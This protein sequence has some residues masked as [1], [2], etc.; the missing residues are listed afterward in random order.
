MGGRHGIGVEALAIGSALP[1]IAVTNAVMRRLA[2]LKRCCLCLGNDGSEQQER[3]K[4]SEHQNG[5]VTPEACASRPVA[6]PPL[7]PICKGDRRALHNCFSFAGGS[8]RVRCYY[9]QAVGP[10]GLTAS[11][12]APAASREGGRVRQC[13]RGRYGQAKAQHEPQRHI[14]P[15]VELA[16]EGQNCSSE[17][18]KK[19]RAC[20]LLFFCLYGAS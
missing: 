8:R 1:V 13:G 20:A 4:K 3:R 15:L 10:G 19:R 7:C 14:V 2:A 16:P 5:E 9:F 6:V 12:V 11:L 18:A 17:A